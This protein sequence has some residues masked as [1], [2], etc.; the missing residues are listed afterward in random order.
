MGGMHQ[1]HLKVT[2]HEQASVVVTMT[3]GGVDY[4]LATIFVEPHTAPF[5]GLISYKDHFLH[6]P[7]CYATVL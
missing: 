4:S 1:L 2:N 5:S 3:G 6:P 7:S